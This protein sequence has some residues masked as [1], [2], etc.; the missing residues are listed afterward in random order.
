M[1]FY[2]AKLLIL[3]SYTDDFRDSE[4]KWEAGSAPFVFL[5]YSIFDMRVPRLAYIF[6]ACLIVQDKK[7]T[8]TN[9]NV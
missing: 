7:K 9:L 8:I 5:V 2:F 6:F 3:L 4:R 1:L